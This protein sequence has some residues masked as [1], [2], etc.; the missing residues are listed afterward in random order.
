MFNSK[1][2]QKSKPFSQLGTL[3]NLAVLLFLFSNAS[4]S[5]PTAE[6]KALIKQSIENMIYVPGGSF[7]MGDGAFTEDLAGHKTD[8]YW[9][10]AY[11]MKPAHK[12]TLDGY[13]LSKVE[14]TNYQYYLYTEA[15]IITWKNRPRHKTRADYPVETD[16]KNAKGFCT[17][18]GELSNLPFDLPTEAQWEYA[19]RSGGQNYL[20]P[21]DNGKLEFGRNIKLI[22]NDEGTDRYYTLSKVGS[23][24]PNPMGFH[25]M[26]ANVP[27]WMSD[28]YYSKYY[29][30]SPERNPKG[31]DVSP[32]KDKQWKSFRGTT[33]LNS[34]EAT[35]GFMTI[36]RQNRLPEYE[37]VGIRCSIQMKEKQSKKELLNAV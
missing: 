22:R 15:K 2:K 13:Y 25:E 33:N 20:F 11:D 7:M 5:A 37:N 17:W 10:G 30:K 16:W 3:V 12:V 18:L 19:A 26:A 35:E 4:F 9:I 29:R 36:L 28:W 31:P 6:Q 1:N 8:E 32:Y 24:P 34:D 27:E 14:V 23:H 21:T